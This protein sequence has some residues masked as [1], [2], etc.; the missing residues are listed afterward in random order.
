MC[1]MSAS[2]IDLSPP[3]TDLTRAPRDL[4]A[5]LRLFDVESLPVLARTAAAIEELR[6]REDSVDAHGLAGV[7][8]QDPLMTLKLFA[9][10]ARLRR[11][12]DDGHP[13]T[14]T[15]ALVMLGIGPFFRTFG[16]QA[17]LEDLLRPVPGALDGVG[18]ILERARRAANFAVAFAVQRMDHDVQVIE[19][20]AR[21]HDFAEILVWLRA[22]LLAG[23]IARR[24][25][26]DPSLRSATVQREVLHVTLPELQHGLMVR[27]RLPPLLVELADDARVTASPQALNV[28]LA[29]R[30]ARHTAQGWQNPALPDD[31]NDVAGLLHMGVE[32]TRLLLQEVD[33]I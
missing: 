23:A 6:E 28:M 16:P 24:Q 14:V 30:L 9:H 15:S 5:W 20:A 1:P 19:A 25:A 26:C 33:A 29:V 13:E 2:S 27:W 10:L 8:G 32:P 4:E 7:I 18:A 31:L 11:G 22:P 21:L 17:S 12:R 3:S